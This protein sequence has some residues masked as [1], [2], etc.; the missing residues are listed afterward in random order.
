LIDT[1]RPC[2]RLNTARAYLERIFR[3]TGCHRQAELVGL[4]AGLAHV[5]PRPDLDI[6]PLQQPHA[7]TGICQ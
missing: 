4:L 7:I 6:S 5:A 2:I 3:K 1:D